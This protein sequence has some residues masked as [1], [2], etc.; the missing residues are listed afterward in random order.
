[1]LFLIWRT[2]ALLYMAG[3]LDRPPVLW[4]VTGKPAHPKEL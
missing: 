1:L 4:I 3:C 2:K